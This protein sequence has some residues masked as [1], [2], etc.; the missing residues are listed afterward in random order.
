M[1]EAN[2]GMPSPEIVALHNPVPAE[3]VRLSLA[4]GF[5][6]EAVR[7][8][9]DRGLDEKDEPDYTR[10]LEYLVLARALLSRNLPDRALALLEH[11]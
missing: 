9:E 6:Q 8:L 1:E 3:R 7:W 2:Q 10:E 5:L 4:Q 11:L